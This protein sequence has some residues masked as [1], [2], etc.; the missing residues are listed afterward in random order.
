MTMLLLS[1]QHV[2]Y[3][4]PLKEA[5]ILDA[6]S[7]DVFEGDFII[8]L[9][10]NGSGKSSLIKIINGLSVPTSGKI[11]LKGQN[12]IGSSAHKRSQSVITLAQDVNLSTFSQMTV[13]EN[14]LMALHRNQRALFTFSTKKER[15]LITSC[16]AT[17]NQKL[18]DKLDEPIATLS[19]GERQTLAFA[20]SVWH[21]P[22]LL[23]L[24]EHTSA[25]DPHMA[26]KLMHLTNEVATQRK[27]TTIMTTHNLEDALAYGN[28]LIVMSKGKVILDVAGK[29]KERLTRT[30]LLTFY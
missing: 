8:L 29:D 18:C 1:L 13:L 30:D 28:R 6:I 2:S 26:V 25:L 11:V 20:M 12:L 3:K 7:L 14:C 9:G 15:Q 17:Y 5:P 4:E 16:L 22:A 27:I 23:L 21:T 19:G 24:D 10:S